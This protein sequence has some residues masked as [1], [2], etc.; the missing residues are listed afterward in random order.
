MKYI[1]FENIVRQPFEA[2]GLPLDME[3]IFE[4]DIYFMCF[5][6]FV[7]FKKLY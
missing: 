7:Q 1:Y 2:Y 4:K 5:I 3:K 6:I